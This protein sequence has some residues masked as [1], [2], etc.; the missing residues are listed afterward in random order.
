[1]IN[2]RNLTDVIQKMKPVISVLLLMMNS[3]VYLIQH[4]TKTGPEQ[5]PY[6]RFHDFIMNPESLLGFDENGIEEVRA[7][8]YFGDLARDEAQIA[9]DDGESA[10][11]FFEDIIKYFFL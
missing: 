5:S 7:S 8:L 3:G 1:M 4:A 10:D 11:V 9:N 6:K 2:R